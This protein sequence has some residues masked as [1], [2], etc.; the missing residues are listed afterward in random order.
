MINLRP[1]TPADFD[2]LIQWVDSEELLITIAGR[3][4][5]FPLTAPQLQTYLDDPNSISFTIT[6]G[7]HEQPI[8]H[9][10]LVRTGEAL[11]K[12]DKLII[13]APG[14]RGKGLGQQVIQALLQ[15][16]FSRLQATTVELNVFDWNT[17]GIRCYEKCG[18]I[19]TPDSEGLY[20]VGDEVW[21][22]FNMK[23]KREDWQGK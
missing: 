20:P 9:A 2:L 23:V 10:E 8:G 17:G 18:F 14:L 15:Y 22:T 21:T 4:F 19:K 16:A 12:I 13:G 11:Y 7:E 3:V 1:F 6:D 5:T